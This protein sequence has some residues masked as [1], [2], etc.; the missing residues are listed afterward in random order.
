MSWLKTRNWSRTWYSLFS[1]ILWKI[2]VE[3]SKQQ[4]VQLE[5]GY[6]W[7]EQ[8]LEK[9]EKLDEHKH[10]L[11]PSIL[12]SLIIN[13]TRNHIIQRSFT[14][15]CIHA[16]EADN[17][18]SSTSPPFLAHASTQFFFAGLFKHFLKL[19]ISLYMGEFFGVCFFLWKHS[20]QIKFTVVK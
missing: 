4:A 12:Q 16:S 18:K 19:K 9:Q 5:I 13:S 20:C 2:F 10:Y 3:L 6:K 15:R 11:A 1:L 8:A 14:L 17:S 7:R